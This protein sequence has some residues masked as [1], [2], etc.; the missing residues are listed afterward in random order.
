MATD[1]LSAARPSRSDRFRGHGAA[2]RG[3]PRSRRRH[4][5]RELIRS[6]PGLVHATEDW[7]TDEALAAGLQFTFAGHASALIRAA[8]T[9]D[10]D[11]VRLLVEAGAPVRDLCDCAGAESPLWA[12]TVGGDRAVV[13]YLLDAGADPNAPAFTGAT[14]L[15]VAMQRGHH[16]LVPRLLAAGADPTASTTMGAPRRLAR[17]SIDRRCGGPGAPGLVP[18]G[19]RAVD[20]F[21]PLHRGRV[22]HW[23]PAVGLGQ[24]VLLF[25]IA[26][27]LAPG[28]V[29][30]S[31]LRARP[32]QPGRRRARDPRDRRRL[33]G[34][35]RA[36]GRGRRAHAR[37]VRECARRLPPRPAAEARRV[38]RRSRA[39]T[40]RHARAP[41]PRRA[42]PMSSV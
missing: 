9:G 8:Q 22:Q 33:P 41:D 15:H 19:I 18:T 5:H 35:P 4:R 2:L 24:T 10:V 37:A 26:A 34:A 30:A 7:S 6:D 27:A 28:R 23:P 11:L 29:L 17:A 20:L 14:P 42:T 31:R 3:D 1:A 25:A 12:A 40:R 21:A 32:L 38:A 16:H 13:E 39:R 36:F